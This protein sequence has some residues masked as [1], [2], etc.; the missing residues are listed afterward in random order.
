[1]ISFEIISI[2]ST[3]K[4]I[5]AMSVGNS[6]FPHQAH[7]RRGGGRSRG[8]VESFVIVWRRSPSRNVLW[9][10]RTQLY[11]GPERKGVL[12]RCVSHGTDSL[13]CAVIALESMDTF[14]FA[15]QSYLDDPH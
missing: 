11:Q 8:R 15:F 3:S 6:G 10:H 14:R 7:S 12:R 9:E 5:C 13:Y 1:M 2:C 4:V